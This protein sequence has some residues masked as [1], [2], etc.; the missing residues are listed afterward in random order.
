MKLEECGTRTRKKE[1]LNALLPDSQGPAF[2]GALWPRRIWGWLTRGW[3]EA[4]GGMRG[5]DPW[6]SQS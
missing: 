5:Q 2:Q 3:A 6:L 1:M 4:G